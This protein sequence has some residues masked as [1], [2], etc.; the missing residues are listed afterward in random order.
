MLGLQGSHFLMNLRKPS[1]LPICKCKFSTV[2]NCGRFAMQRFLSALP[3]QYSGTHSSNVLRPWCWVSTPRFLAFLSSKLSQWALGLATASSIFF[4]VCKQCVFSTCF[5]HPVHDG[6]WVIFVFTP[7]GLTF[8]FLY[9]HN[10]QVA[11]IE[12]GFKCFLC[13]ARGSSTSFVWKQ[14]ATH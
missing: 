11:H 5:T 9:K 4:G 12:I 1:W 8:G 10:L 2:H 3:C 6:H 13:P 7:N 14:F